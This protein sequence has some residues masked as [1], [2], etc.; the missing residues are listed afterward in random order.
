MS[1]ALDHRLDEIAS[2]IGSRCSAGWGVAPVVLYSLLTTG[3][4]R[5]VGY[6]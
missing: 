5:D 2:R 3:H 4:P 6:R 1:R